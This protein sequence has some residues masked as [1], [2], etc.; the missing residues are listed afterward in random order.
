MDFD[1]VLFMAENGQGFRFISKKKWS[2]RLTKLKEL[3]FQN[4][5]VWPTEILK[6][7]FLTLFY[8]SNLY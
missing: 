1:M 3:G 6:Q 5:Y 7:I 4:K 8:F 2:G